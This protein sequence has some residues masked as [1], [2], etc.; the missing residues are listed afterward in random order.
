MQTP[1]AQGAAGGLASQAPEAEGGPWAS[2]LSMFADSKLMPH[3]LIFS[4]QRGILAMLS[5]AFGKG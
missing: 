2:D 5:I 3:S 4:T 1:H